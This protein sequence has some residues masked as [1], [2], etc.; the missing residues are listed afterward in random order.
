MLKSVGASCISIC[1]LLGARMKWHTLIWQI[2]YKINLFSLKWARIFYPI[3]FKSI[4]W[5]SRR[6]TG[7]SQSILWY[8]ADLFSMGA[9]LKRDSHLPRSKFYRSKTQCQCLYACDELQI[10]AHRTLLLEDWIP[11]YQIV[12]F[13]LLIDIHVFKHMT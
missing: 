13:S 1:Q 12:H 9:T 2:S 11:S 10:D 5:N 8:V 3:K 6:L 4:R 7:L